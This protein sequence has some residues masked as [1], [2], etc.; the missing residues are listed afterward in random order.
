MVRITGAMI[1]VGSPFKKL[2]PVD[3]CTGDALFPVRQELDV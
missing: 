1:V 3:L 2:K